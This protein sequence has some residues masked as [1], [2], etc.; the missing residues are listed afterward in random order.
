[1]NEGFRKSIEEGYKNGYLS[2]KSGTRSTKKTEPIHTLIS[3][4]LKG[5]FKNESGI[6]IFSQGIN[7]EF[8]FEGK[9]YKKNLDITVVKN[10][11]PVSSI[12]FKFITSNYKQNANN[13]FE[14]MLGETAN[15]RRNGLFY[16]Q[17]IVFRLLMPYYSSDYKTYTKMEIINEQNLK[18]YLRLES[19]EASC[20]YHRPDMMLIVF[21]SVGDEGRYQEKID[22]FK[23][24]KN[25]KLSKNEIKNLVKI[26]KTEFFDEIAN[27]V[28]VK[29]LSIDEVN[30]ILQENGEEKLSSEMESFLRKHSDFKSFITSFVK[31]TQARFY[32]L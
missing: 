6:E 25:K 17:I 5:C 22:K 4:V 31:A 9:Y 16:A 7:K 21:V 27:D 14:N 32:G 1:M 26:D 23:D 20:L 11:V 29:I 15:I 10:R 30:R 24:V 8:S 12:G 13:Y 18:K 28:N 3:N 19:D 2:S